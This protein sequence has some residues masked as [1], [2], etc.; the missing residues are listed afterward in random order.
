M[1]IKKHITLY[2][3]I[4]FFIGNISSQNQPLFEQYHF[5]Q[6]MLNPAYAGSKSTIEANIF[7][8]QQWLRMEGAPQSV[9]ATVHTKLFNDKIGLG[10]KILQE[11]IGATSK[12]DAGI[13][14]AYR[15]YM[16]NAVLAIGINANVTNYR[17]KYNNLDAFLDGDPAFTNQSVNT[18]SPN[19]GAG[20]WFNTEK[21]YAGLSA[22]LLLQDT[23][24]IN[25]EATVTQSNIFEARRH[26]YLSSGILL[27]DPEAF[28]IK[29]YTLIKYVP[30]APWQIDINMSFIFKNSFWFGG[31]YRTNN[32]VSILAE[33]F[34]QKEKMLKDNIFGFGYA[35]N[36]SLGDYQK[37]FGPTH[38]IFFSYSFNKTTSK[39]TNPRFF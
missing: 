4:I 23:T 11:E 16:T 3:I 37:F 14:Y 18:W 1:K 6:L 15:V 34:L 38:E 32:S 33:Y 10:L 22:P 21:I 8:R 12:F 19:V 39:Y 27:G 2:I 26:Y 20:V 31:S 17:L 5:N 35:Y 36:F 7:Y 28:A 25:T 13:Q 24:E 29:P 9:S 30:A